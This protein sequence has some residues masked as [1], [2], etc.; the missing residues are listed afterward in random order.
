V[1]TSTS[2]LAIVLLAAAG[3]GGSVELG[4]EDC[5]GRLQKCD[6]AVR[7]AACAA[8]PYH[9]RPPVQ[10]R[11]VSVVGLPSRQAGGRS[12]QAAQPEEAGSAL[13]GAFV[14]EVLHYLG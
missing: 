2:L 9:R 14:G 1:K 10:L 8:A 7:V 13:G 6:S 11:Q 4:F 3:A 12:G 5:Q